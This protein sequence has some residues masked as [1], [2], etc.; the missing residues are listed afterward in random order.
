MQNR[1]EQNSHN[2]ITG[3]LQTFTDLQEEKFIRMWQLKASYI[4]PIAHKIEE[5][6]KK[7]WLRRPK[8]YR[9]L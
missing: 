1:T 6:G 4:I 5:D 3:K 7:S 2:T 8:L 9:E